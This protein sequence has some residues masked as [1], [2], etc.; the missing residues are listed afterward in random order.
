[1]IIRAI[2]LGIVLVVLSTFARSST[3][4]NT[5]QKVKTYH[6]LINPKVELD[7]N[8]PIP[9]LKG[10]TII[11]N[12]DGTFTVIIAFICGRSA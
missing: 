3:I 11:A 10:S 2:I 9:H 4:E 1:M 7:C 6:S 5:Y 8:A 12:A